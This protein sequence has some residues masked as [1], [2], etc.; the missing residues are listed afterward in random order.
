MREKGADF[1]QRTSCVRKIKK[2]KIP[3]LLK[4]GETDATVVAL[5]EFMALRCFTVKNQSTIIR[6]YLAASR[7]QKSVGGWGFPTD[8]SMV[9]AIREGIDRSHAGRSDAAT[10]LRKI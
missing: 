3:W 7:N 10:N 4:R 2:N 6:G 1:V 5:T 9:L 8:H